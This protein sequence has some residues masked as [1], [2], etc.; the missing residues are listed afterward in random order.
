MRYVYVLLLTLSYAPNKY[1][2]RK[3][4]TFKTCL[5]TVF[6]KNS[7]SIMNVFSKCFQIHRCEYFEIEL[8]IRTQFEGRAI[9]CA[10]VA[11]ANYILQTFFSE[12]NSNKTFPPCLK[13]F[14][15]F[16]FDEILE[17][18]TC[19]YEY[20]MCINFKNTF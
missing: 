14:I 5:H 2:K 18:S 16:I 12:K 17:K 19:S 4:D 10:P 9:L 11:L 15:H 6:Y 13:R 1:N 20:D 3:D 8:I 7:R